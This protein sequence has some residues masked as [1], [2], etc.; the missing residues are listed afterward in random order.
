METR[1]KI[2]LSLHCNESNSFLFA[3][4][5]ICCVKVIFE[6][7]LQLIIWKKNRIKEKCKIFSV[8]FNLVDTNNIYFGILLHVV[9]TKENI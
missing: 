7:I 4:T 3:D 1:K 9:A 5:L 2:L 8:D 6:K